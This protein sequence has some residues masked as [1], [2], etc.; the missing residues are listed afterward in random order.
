MPPPSLF[1]H[2]LLS[3]K[4]TSSYQRRRALQGRRRASRSSEGEDAHVFLR[5]RASEEAQLGLL[6]AF[7]LVRG[8][9]EFARRTLARLWG[10]KKFRESENNKQ[11]E[12]IK[13]AL[14]PPTSLFFFFFFISWLRERLPLLLFLSL[15]LSTGMR[16]SLSMT[17]RS[18]S[19]SSCG[20]LSRQA[21]APVQQQQLLHKPAAVFQRRRRPALASKKSLVGVVTVSALGQVRPFDLFPSFPRETKPSIDGVPLNSSGE[22]YARA[23]VPLGGE[24]A[25]SLGLQSV[26]LRRAPLKKKKENRDRSPSIV[27]SPPNPPFPDLIRTFLQ[28][29]TR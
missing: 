4:K 26:C 5:E 12:K 29:P 15:S 24:L 16:S 7:F 20:S 25:R 27:P 17:M 2:C 19:I 13:T 8:R 1:F 6:R 22:E 14:S 10:K 3:A 9:R 18:T 11:V 21:A 28:S 23:L